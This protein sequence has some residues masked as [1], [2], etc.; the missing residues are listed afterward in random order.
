MELNKIVTV[1]AI[2]AGILSVASMAYTW[3]LSTQVAES[4]ESVAESLE[5]ISTIKDI[6]GLTP[7]VEPLI[8]AAMEEGEVTLYT[9]HSIEIAQQILDEFEKK[10]PFI[11]T[12]LYRA[13]SSTI[14]QKFMTEHDAGKPVADILHFSGVHLA[15]PLIE[16]GLIMAYEPPEANELD[17]V[18]KL[19]PYWYSTRVVPL[20]PF[21][22]TDLLNKTTIKSWQDITDPEF[23][24]KWKGRV[25]M[26]DPRYRGSG[27][28]TYYFYREAFGIEF[29]EQMA[30]LDI[31]WMRSAAVE[32]SMVV[33]GE[34]VMSINFVG[35]RIPLL[36]DEGAPVDYVIPEEGVVVYPVPTMITADAPN[37]NAAKLLLRYLLSK[38][39]AKTLVATFNVVP[40]KGLPA[41]K[42][43]PPLDEIATCPQDYVVMAAVDLEELLTEWEDIFGIG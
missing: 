5:S 24:E 12:N 23:I 20:V 31:K 42:H 39:G 8:K 35:H 26:S 10:Y 30:K 1:I 17:D 2:V 18:Y 27:A 29:W 9:S 3:T 16:Q 14:L 33:S 38:E 37:P 28:M 19:K 7:E 22:N 41:V 13:G 11:T 43:L 15:T 34:A 32:Q 40:Q 21:F 36:I 4:L 6:L 25:L